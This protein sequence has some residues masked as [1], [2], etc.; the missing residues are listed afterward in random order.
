MTK[1]ESFEKQA[2]ELESVAARAAN[3]LRAQAAPTMSVYELA[4]ALRYVV[5]DGCSEAQS[6]NNAQQIF[7]RVAD[8]RAGEKPYAFAS[9]IKTP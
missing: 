7:E 9:E 2:L 8:V 5:D 4:E 6:L 1:K 3:A